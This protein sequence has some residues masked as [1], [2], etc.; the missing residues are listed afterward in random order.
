[1]KPQTFIRPLTEDERTTLESGCRAPDALTVRR[2]PILLASAEG[3]SPSTI[4]RHLRCARQTVYHVFDA[5]AERGLD[6]LRHGS[7]VPV[8]V[9]PVLTAE[10]REHL[11][12]LLHQSPRTFGQAQSD[13]TLKLLA[14]VC[15]EHGLSDRPLSPPT[16]LDAGVRWGA[17]W[18]RAKHWMVSPAPA[19]TRKNTGGTASSA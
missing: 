7:Q 13:W 9:A 2:C 6:G 8:S 10:K 5:F 19:Y 1:M 11:P 17:S 4:A 3:Q 15:H 18:K 12:A 16:L 14:A